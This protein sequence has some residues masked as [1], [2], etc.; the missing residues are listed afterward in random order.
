MEE[1][2]QKVAAAKQHWQKFCD[3]LAS[4]GL[5]ALDNL[6][7]DT[8]LDLAEGVRY[9]SRIAR[10]ALE[11]ELENKDSAHPYLQRSLGPTLK[12]GGDNPEGLYL[13][14]PINGTDTF[15]ITGSRG[16][17]DWISF[18]AQRSYDALADGLTVFGDC[19]FS[20]ELK[21]DSEGR[22]CITIAPEGAFPDSES[23][24]N[25]IKT[26][27]YCSLMLIR[28]FFSDRDDVSPMDLRIEN[29]TRG[30]EPK[31]LLTLPEVG[32]R[33]D[34]S[35]AF[36]D[37][38]VPIMQQEMVDQGARLN[39]FETDIGN[40]TSNTGG[41]PGGNGVTARWALNAD[42]ALLV[43]FTPPSSCPYWD[44][45]VG[46]GWY[47]SWDYRHFFS[48]MT[49]SQAHY[50]A[51]GSVTVVVSEQDP[52]TVNW[53]QAAGHE[54]GHIAVRWLLTD[55]ELPLPDCQVVSV[56]AVSSLVDL[57]TVLPSERD[58][59]KRRHRESVE[60]RFRL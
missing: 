30:H 41:V 3:S 47:E 5:Q 53:L 2:L 15:Q 6:H 27:K 59:Q 35:A 39:T 26:D 55:G 45:Q 24:D 58:Q 44:I 51:D 43:T 37:M 11:S 56:S 42:E 14:A 20:T 60:R 19:L 31:A 36:F 33:L 28:Q 13:A 16:S 12:M 17:A 40:P 38:M 54:Q 48:G 25:W 4:T 10:L 9:L 7:I 52:G 22:I 18:F 50:N 23:P 46:N 21:S 8:D 32:K 49:H 29:L 34:A 1:K 57:E